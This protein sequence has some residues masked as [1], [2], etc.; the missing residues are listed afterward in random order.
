M[1][2]QLPRLVLAFTLVLASVGPTAAQP[3]F[4]ALFG[5]AA[6]PNGDLLVADSVAGV[7]PIGRKGQGKALPIPGATR[8][9]SPIGR[10]SMWV[11]TGALTED[12]TFDSGQGL[13][14]RSTGQSKK[15]A[16]L[17]EFEAAQNPDGGAVESNPFDVQALGGGG[18]LVTDAAGNDLL[19][20]DARGRVEVLAVFPVEIVSTTPIKTL[21]GCPTPPPQWAFVCGLPPALPAEAVPTSIAL[22]SDGSIYVGE[23]KGFPAPTGES[24]IWRVSPEASGAQC[25]SSPDCVKVFAGGFTSIIDLEVGSDGRLLVAELDE[26]SWIALEGAGPTLGGTV[27]SCDLETHTCQEVASGIPILTAI[28]TDKNGTLWAT[29]FAL[30][31]GLA[32]IVS[33]P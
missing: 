25:G 1:S 14:R 20:V 5:L 16:N 3:G 15:I 33:L 6:A 4:T 11:V 10:G 17:F 31:P 18:A 30:V 29:R 23:L 12:G 7:I 28:A 32:E 8:D 9:V 22:G 13:H 26:A 21:V 27:S 19:Y 2:K 24:N